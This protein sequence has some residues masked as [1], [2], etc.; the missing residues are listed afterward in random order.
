MGRVS[1]EKKQFRV[2]V[3]NLVEFI[4][5]SG[6]IDTGS[7]VGR[8][9]EAMQAGSRMHKKIQRRAGAE[10]VP[11]VP[12]KYVLDTGRYEL[13]IEGRADGV[14]THVQEDG[15]ADV[16]IDEI[17]SMYSDVT[18]FR[19]PRML[20]LA[21]AKCYACIYAMQEGLEEIAVRLTYCNLET[22]EVKLF[23]EQFA[24]RELKVW[25]DQLVL[26]YQ[27]WTDHQYEWQLLRQETIRQIRFPWP[28]REGQFELV[29]DVYRS[30][31]REKLLF[32]QAPTGTGKTISTIFPSVKAMGEELIN[33]IFYL[34]ARTVTAAVAEDTC[35]LL[36]EQGLRMKV[37]RILAKEKL[38]PMETCICTPESCPRAKGH[39]DRV[40]DAM[41]E[42]LTSGDDFYP[43]LLKEQAERCCVCP[44]EMALDL[45][46]WADLVI[47]DY[48]YVFDPN[49]RLKRFFADGGKGD[50]VFLIDE[51]HNLVDRGR[52]MFSAELKKED[53]LRI[54]RLIRELAA[55]SQKKGPEGTAG[56][57]QAASAD[58]DSAAAGGTDAAEKTAVQIATAGSGA[59]YRVSFT[60]LEQAFTSCNRKLLEWKRESDRY[61]IRESL[62][63]LHFSLMR[64][65]SLM[66]VL[67]R[68]YRGFPGR[69]E[70]LEFFFLLRHFLNMAELLDEHYVIYTDFE[71]NGDFILQLY[72]VDPSAN[73]QECLDQAVSAV[74]FSATMLPI[75]YYKQLLSTRQ[76]NY[77]IYAK[78]S[79][80]QE[81]QLLYIAPGVSTLYRR[82]NE[83]EY[84]GIAACIL[85]TVRGK[86][87]NYLVFCPSYQ[88][89]DHIVRHVTE[90]TEGCEDSFRCVVQERGMKEEERARFLSE[91]SKDSGETLV[92]FCVLGGIFS[93][94]IDLT[95]DQLIG[96][97][98][99]GTGLPQVCT[100]RE[101]L[102]NYYEEQGKDGFAYAYLYPGMNKVQQAAGRVIRTIRDRGVI[103]LLDERFLRSE[104][105]ELFPREWSGVRVLHQNQILRAVREFW[106]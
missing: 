27:K 6:D 29:R 76:D 56:V 84:A 70:V 31:S 52:E 103:G 92:G 78:T 68:E 14:I 89:Q 104:Y 96:A 106:E 25:F 97:L 55:I 69:D 62:G 98:V 93:E 49:V 77:A 53:L 102:K 101:I 9:A 73:L 94:G 105:R 4:L 91:F 28:Y 65:H 39:F 90:M 5:R 23:T 61:Q 24:A 51:A 16:T 48:N 37:I 75:R 38:C 71:Q 43:E 85:E 58:Q 35:A 44:F 21:Q 87:G 26:D 59:E 66:E 15:H 46:E 81:Q 11:E 1:M 19:E 2:S 54:R 67:L 40:N 33:R 86:K 63:S 8:Q 47:C 95:G 74:F 79:F 36:K 42:L 30:V 100:R 10:Y 82:R 13:R 80:S 12:L 50:Y 57:E 88:L 83:K 45:S 18:R 32:L 60:R 34:T 41:Y 7:G 3:R 72:C 17:K 22:E 20:H 99:V 64:L